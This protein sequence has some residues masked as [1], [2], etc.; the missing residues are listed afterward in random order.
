MTTLPP[1]VPAAQRTSPSDGM[2]AARLRRTVPA[3]TILGKRQLP[4]DILFE[5]AFMRAMSQLQIAKRRALMRSACGVLDLGIS[6][7]ELWQPRSL[8]GR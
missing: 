1:A 4:R 3:A 6:L 5:D 7:T 2:A 8:S